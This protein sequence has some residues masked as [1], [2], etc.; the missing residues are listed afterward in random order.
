MFACSPSRNSKRAS[1]FIRAP[2]RV[3]G[4]VLISV[5]LVV[6]IVAGLAVKF[7]S[8]YQLGLA[9]AESRWHGGQARQFLEGTEEV[10]KIL[11]PLADLDPNTDYLGEP[12]SNEVPI[13]DDGVAGV[14]RLTDA[15][16]Q[17]NLNEL[18]TALVGDKPMGSPE[19]YSE[20]QRRFIR[21]LQTFETQLPLSQQEAEGLLEGLVDWID[22]DSNE[23]GSYGA[24]ANYYQSQPD[25][26]RPA[27]SLMR[28]LDEL[29][30]V[31]GFDQS[32]ELVA[33]LRPFITVLPSD[34][35]GWNL[36]TV[37]P[38]LYREGTSGAE[39]Y[40]NNLVRALG[41]ATSLTPIG[42]MDAMQFMEQRGETGFAD[43]T[44]M[45]QAWSKLFS[46]DALATEGITVK[47]SFF[48]LNATVEIG[49][50]RRSQRSLMLRDG[51]NNL[52]VVYRE[53]V[54]ELPEVNH[55]NSNKRSSRLR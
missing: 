20:P 2:Q 44:E 4:A 23:S 36:N 26:Y 12:W 34:A 27:N 22:Q 50:Q 1:A 5:L 40:G 54:Y 17:L 31:R 28:S 13:Q 38:V 9:R 8:D 7:A 16:A 49:E 32:P 25:P 10:A 15:T 19:R 3:R 11:F 47:S 21:L 14:A 52:V 24:E 6:A 53:D 43:V 42:D 33:L 45:Q 41:S 35:V 55:S 51:N 48:W 37:E 29:R 46:G 39:P 30:L 18:A